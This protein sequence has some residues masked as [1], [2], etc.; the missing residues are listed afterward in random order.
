MRAVNL[1]PADLRGAVKASATVTPSAEDNGGSGAFFALGALALCALALAGYVLTTNTIKQ[2]KAD[3]VALETRNQAVLAETAK[4]KPYADFASMAQARITTVH[5]LASQRFDWEGSLRDLARALPGDVSVT[6][7]DGSI[8]SSAGGTSPLRTA[9]DVPAIELTGCTSDQPA[10]ARLM[11]RL[12]AVD[13]VTRVSLSDTAKNA[14]PAAIVDSSVSAPLVGC[15]GKNGADPTDFDVLVFFEGDAAAAVDPAA[16][17]PA[18][19]AA[20]GAATTPS[21][22]TAPAAT[23]APSADAP[24]PTT[25]TS[26]STVTEAK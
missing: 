12:R 4:L 23:P 26:S 15:E 25:E 6:A 2:H 20:P 11:S 21:G 10:V 18:A 19:G 8:S 3:L 24:A 9:L 14:A 17:A 22:T 1:L 13:G 16:P 7:L 5:D